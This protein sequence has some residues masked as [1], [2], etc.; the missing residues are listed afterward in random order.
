MKR[1]IGLSH[2]GSLASFGAASCCVLP[3]ALMLAGLGG[4]WVVIFAR[5]AAVGYYVLA[6]SALVLALA[7]IVAYRRGVLRRLAWRLGASTGLSALAGVILVNEARINDY[8]I[9]LM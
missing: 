6:A 8:F 9:G 4:S 7:W 3:T 5:I 1:L 2:L